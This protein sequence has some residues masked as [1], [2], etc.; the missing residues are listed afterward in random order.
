[1]KKNE[2]QAIIDSGK[3][4]IVAEYRGGHGEVIRWKSKDTQRQEEARVCTHALETAGGEQFKISERL[5]EGTDVLNVR[6][7]AKRGDHVLVVLR[8]WH[9]EKGNVQARGE[10]SVIEGG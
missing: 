9:V 7:P 3:P 10:I 2:V 8:S 5:A 4:V 1:M 6:L